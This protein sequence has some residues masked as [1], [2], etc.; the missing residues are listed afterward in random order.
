MGVHYV[1]FVVVGVVGISRA[2]PESGIQVSEWL[3]GS[4]VVQLV[5]TQ[6][7]NIPVNVGD[8]VVE[9]VDI[10]VKPALVVEAELEVQPFWIR[11]GF[12]LVM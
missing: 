9:V 7:V 2:E 1:W 4:E 12:S 11:H 3:D 5:T 6:E 10:D 8:T